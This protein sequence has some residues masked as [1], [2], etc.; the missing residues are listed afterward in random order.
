MPNHA[1]LPNRKTWTLF[2]KSEVLIQRFVEAFLLM[3]SR[4]FVGEKSKSELYVL[5]STS[6][7]G[8][9]PRLLMVYVKS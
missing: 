1:C 7:L 6:I 3:I 2:A 4:Y 5:M 9:L 8:S